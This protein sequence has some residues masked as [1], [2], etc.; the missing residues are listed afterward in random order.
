[1]QSTYVEARV[2]SARRIQVAEYAL[3]GACGWEVP[4][5]IRVLPVSE[6]YG[7]LEHTL[8]RHLERIYRER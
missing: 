1:M 3:E 6:T 5:E 8:T 2:R 4:K 7:N